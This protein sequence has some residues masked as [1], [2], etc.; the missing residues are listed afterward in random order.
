[1]TIEALRRIVQP[2]GDPL[3]ACLLPWNVA[4]RMRPPA[5]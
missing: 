1:M 2:L 4:A 5:G 3:L